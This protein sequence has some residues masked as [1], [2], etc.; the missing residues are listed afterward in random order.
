LGP[1]KK[2]GFSGNRRSKRRRTRYVR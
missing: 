1:E 2:K